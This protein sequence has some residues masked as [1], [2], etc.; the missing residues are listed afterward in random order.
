MANHSHTVTLTCAKS[1]Y[2]LSSNDEKCYI[3][4]L[5][6]ELLANNILPVITVY[7][8][9]DARPADCA[10]DVNGTTHYT[11]INNII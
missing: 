2:R 10:C 5:Q 7:I 11:K 9:L 1:L 6:M 4:R 3:E 8:I